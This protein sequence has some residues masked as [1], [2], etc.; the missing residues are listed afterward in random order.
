MSLTESP[1]LT[2]RTPRSP[3]ICAKSITFLLNGNA[4]TCDVGTATALIEKLGAE[5]GVDVKVIDFTKGGDLQA[6]ARE[7]TEQGAAIVAA[8]GGDGTINAVASTLVGTDTVLGVLPLG[9]LNHFAKDLGIPLKLEDA[10]R[11]LFEGKTAT[12]DVAEINGKVFLNNSSLGLYPRIVRQRE[13]HQ[14]RGLPKWIALLP[15]LFYVA[16]NHSSLYLRL[17]VDDAQAEFRKTPFIFIGN[18]KYELAGLQIGKRNSLAGARL[19]ICK[20]PDATR[21]G[22]LRLTLRALAGRLKDQDLEATEAKEAWIETG[23]RHVHVST[24]GEVLTMEG[25]LHYKSRPQALKVIVPQRAQPA[26]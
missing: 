4:G 5:H 26:A 19:W 17:K 1:A 24:D 16:R 2:A 23:S 20:A 25:P 21:G 18:N 13:A 3:P 15:A 8:G 6:L 7:A 11:T 12:I 22:L 14:K 10:V 9:T